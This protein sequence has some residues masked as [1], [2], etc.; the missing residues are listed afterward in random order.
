[1]T[2]TSRVTEAW[3]RG[4]TDIQELWG[5]ILHITSGWSLL[6]VRSSRDEAGTASAFPT[7][8]GLLP[9]R[10]IWRRL[11]S[12]RYE[13]VSRRV[14]GVEGSATTSHA[15][16]GLAKSAGRAQAPRRRAT[17]GRGRVERPVIKSVGRRHK[18]IRENRQG[19]PGVL[20]GSISGADLS[21]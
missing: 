5:T 9:W 10:F 13:P 16:P 7:T 1:M 4:R 20:Y 8:A 12:G 14:D 11:L 3:T 21:T 2:A 19:P 6:Q 15:G 18:T 17:G